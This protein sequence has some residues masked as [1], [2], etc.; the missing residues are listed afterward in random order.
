LITVVGAGLAGSLLALE[1]ADRGLA[2]RLIEAGTA[3]G[4]TALSYG[5]LPWSAGRAWRRL[6]RRHGDLG[7]RQRWLQRGARGLPLPAL[8]VDGQRFAAAMQPILQGL[9]VERRTDQPSA[10]PQTPVVLACGAGCRAL[11]PHLDAR[12]RVSWAGILE[13]EPGPA[14]A[15]LGWRQG[16]AQLPQRFGR[17]AL[18][19]RAPELQQEAWVVDGGLVPCGDRLLAGQISLIRPGLEAGQGP[20]AAVMEQRLRSALAAQW[21]DLATAPGQ[22]RQCAVS[23]CTDGRPLAG[24]CGPDQWVLAG[25]SGAFAQVPDAAHGMAD[26]LAAKWA[27]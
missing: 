20:D 23:F 25:F 24:P 12:L 5:L 1:L 21:P 9:G 2:V 16:L 18:E 17:Q 15:W 10:A 4:A 3:A 22:Y 13:L 11:A 7:L 6:Q 27:P 26:Q 14:G 19:R 8:Q